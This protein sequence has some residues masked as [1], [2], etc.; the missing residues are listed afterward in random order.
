MITKKM[1]NVKESRAIYHGLLAFALLCVFSTLLLMPTLPVYAASSSASTSSI[2]AIPPGTYSIQSDANSLYVSAE[3]S[4]P[5]PYNGL[6]RA[7]ASRISD[8]ERFYLSY[9]SSSRTYSIQSAAN[10]LYVSA[11][12]SNGGMLRASASSITGWER[13]KLWTL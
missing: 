6:L 10:T 9:D 11:E 5:S 8:W 2:N 1:L 12:L 7:R 4:Y 13:F 3:L